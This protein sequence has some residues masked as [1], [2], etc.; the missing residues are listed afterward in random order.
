MEGAVTGGGAGVP[1][2]ARELRPLGVGDV[3]DAAVKLYTRNAVSMWKIVACVVV[4]VSLINQI[5]VGA[6]LPSGAYVYHGTLYT[7]TGQLSTPAAGVIA[8]IVLSI[9][10]VLIANGALSLS[11]VDA[12]IGQPL[13]WVASLRAA[14]SRLGSLL[15]LAILW[16]VLV[17]VG[18]IAII[19]PGIW[20]LV[21][22]SVG[23]PALMFEHL[24]GFK[25]LGRSFDLVRGRWWAT[26][27]ELL[28]AIIMLVLVSL[29][30]GLI[31][32]AI[33]KGLKVDSIGLWLAFNWLIA[34]F[35]DLVSYPFIAAVI[36]VIYIDLRV[37]KEALDLELLAG[38]LGS[39][40]SAA[41]R[42]VADFPAQTST[43]PPTEP[44]WPQAG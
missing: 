7:P 5:I 29:V 43:P 32:G 14:G 24:G 30:L 35:S 41:Q 38:G 17:I 8:G 18:F 23:I 40:S 15:W 37:R 22:W 26:F 27:A 42:A 13:D 4:P 44:S 11:L 33:E 16:T 20:L 21:V 2:P 34:L 1:S 6:S 25:A 19:L 10:A 3:L 31:L 39:P 28:V 9:V 12:Y 36:A